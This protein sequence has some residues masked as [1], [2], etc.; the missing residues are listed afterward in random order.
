[1][2][3]ILKKIFTKS[4]LRYKSGTHR[5][6]VIPIGGIS[7]TQSLS[8]IKQMMSNY[9]EVIDW[10]DKLKEKRDNKLMKL[11]NLHGPLQNEEIWINTPFSKDIWV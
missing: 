3:Q 10:P 2:K 7:K 9:N 6:Y 4:K 11:L 8:Q 1:M 5:K